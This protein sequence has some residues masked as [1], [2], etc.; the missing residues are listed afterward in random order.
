MM[1]KFFIYLILAIYL[2]FVLVTVYLFIIDRKTI[3]ITKWNRIKVI[4]FH[5]IFMVTYVHAA[6]RA[7]FVKPSWDK[8]EH[9]INRTDL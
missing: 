9:T 5:P 1:K 2:L 3:K 7:I 8:I 4:F 6:I